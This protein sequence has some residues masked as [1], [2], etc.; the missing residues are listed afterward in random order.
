MFNELLA[1]KYFTIKL[2][3]FRPS[4]FRHSSHE[5]AKLLVARLWATLPH[6]DHATRC[7]GSTPTCPSMCARL[8][9]RSPV[10]R[11]T[12]DARTG[13]KTPH[14]TLGGMITQAKVVYCRPI[15]DLA[16]AHETVNQGTHNGRMFCWY[17]VIFLAKAFW[18]SF[19]CF[20]E[21]SC[22][23]LRIES[24]NSGASITRPMLHGD[25]GW[26]CEQ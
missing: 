18:P 3:L 21:G 25:D 23:V 8:Q 20:F 24:S 6:Y 26:Y 19:L 12:L 1:P 17:F 10:Q 14:T 11:H 22:V 7:L 5:H 16:N 4:P 9:R 2:Y 13:V 15:C